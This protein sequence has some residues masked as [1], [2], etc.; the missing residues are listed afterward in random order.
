MIAQLKAL[1]TSPFWALLRLGAAIISLAPL[2]TAF[3]QTIETSVPHAILVDAD[4]G[5]VLFEKDADAPVTPASTVKTMTAEVVFHEL[6][7]GRIK[8]DDQFLISENAWRTGGAPAR[9]SSMFA[10]L[11]SRVRVEDLIRGLV[12]DLGNDAAIALAGVAGSEGAFATLMMKR[13]RELG[14]TKSIFTNSWG[15]DDPEQKSHPARDDASRR[16]CDPDLS[17]F[18]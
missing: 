5:S 14:L 12:I 13:G 8:L 11:N 9:A 2:D 7:E 18:L 6:T 1:R 10:A 17:R 15:K 16:A 4:T 3:A